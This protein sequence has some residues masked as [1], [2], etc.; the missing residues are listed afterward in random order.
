MDTIASA[1]ASATS[2]LSNSDS[3]RLDAE[4]LLCA[5]LGESRSYL[6]TWPEKVL[7]AAQQQQFAALLARRAAG[8]PVAHI[9]G[10]P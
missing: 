2:L 7:S 1:L 9:L 8:D 5:V 10:E 6:F 3:P 4:L